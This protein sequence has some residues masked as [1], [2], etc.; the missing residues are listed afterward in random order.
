M[1]RKSVGPVRNYSSIYAKV[2]AKRVEIKH[3]FHKIIKWVP[4]DYVKPW[5]PIRSCDLRPLQ[6]TDP[7]WLKL[8]FR[9]FSDIIDKLPEEHRKLFTVEYGH[10]K[11]GVD[12]IMED[13]LS[14]V[15]CHLFDT[16]SLP[17]KIARST[18]RIR[19]LQDQFINHEMT[20]RSGGHRITCKELIEKRKK[21]LRRL[22]KADYKCFEWILDVLGIIFKPDYK[23]V[24]VQRRASIN[25]LVHMLCNEI[26]D[27]KMKEYKNL[28]EYEKIPF[29]EMK[30][31]TLNKIKE[32]ESSINIPCSVDEDIAATKKMLDNL[33][34]GSDAITIHPVAESSRLITS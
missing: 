15:K 30:L 27:K 3:D 5:H 26:R 21:W 31:T 7:N 32:D 4:P 13:T 8:E 34:K 10:R 24:F 22:R 19:S 9:P 1:L 29:L 28:L 16:T 14:Q 23:N 25:V 11:D 17:Y 18:I 12:V 20:L 6:K 33:K 2:V